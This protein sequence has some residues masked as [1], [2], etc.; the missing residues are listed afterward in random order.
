MDWIAASVQGRMGTTLRN[1]VRLAA[2]VAVEVSSAQP[3]DFSSLGAMEYTDS[4]LGPPR[5]PSCCTSQIS[6]DAGQRPPGASSAPTQNSMV[7]LVISFRIADAIDN[8]VPGVDSLSRF[9]T[10]ELF[11][12]WSQSFKVSVKI[13]PPL[14][15]R[16]LR[17]ETL[18]VPIRFPAARRAVRFR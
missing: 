10:C 12:S 2:R 16:S 9:L 7:R 6:Q 11:F 5:L 3:A 15:T 4:R 18:V 8:H 14:S 13:T 1:W 17:I